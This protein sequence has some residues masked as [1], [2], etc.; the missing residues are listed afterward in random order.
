MA[1]PQ[2]QINNGIGLLGSWGLT[3]AGTI[4]EWNWVTILSS[5]A[6]TMLTLSLATLRFVEA[7]IKLKD[8]QRG[9]KKSNDGDGE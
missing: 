5:L 9:H 2:R 8:A 6:A 4:M 1:L 3:A 7:Y